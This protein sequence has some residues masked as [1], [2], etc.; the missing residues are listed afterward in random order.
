MKD[1]VKIS[2]SVSQG[3]TLFRI[4]N[5]KE[6]SNIIRTITLVS[7]FYSQDCN[8]WHFISHLRELSIAWQLQDNN[9]VSIIKVKLDH[10]IIM[11]GKSGGRHGHSQWRVLSQHCKKRSRR[12]RNS[13][14]M[15]VPYFSHMKW[16]N[17]ATVFSMQACCKENNRKKTETLINTIFQL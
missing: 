10:E 13:D 15:T 8:I 9:V 14:R 12:T 4:R 3:P 11:K 7:W 16:E 6:W 2:I 5:N 17:S 1:F